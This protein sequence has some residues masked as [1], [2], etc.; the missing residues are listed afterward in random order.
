MR[1]CRTASVWVSSLSTGFLQVNKK[2]AE[3]FHLSV[4]A[5]KVCHAT[6][7]VKTSRAACDGCIAIAWHMV[8]RRS[9]CQLGLSGVQQLAT[10]ECT[11]DPD[12]QLVRLT[13]TNFATNAEAATT[14]HRL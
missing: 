7:Q 8:D 2:Q 6:H 9:R 4:L 12:W 10:R 3:A 1:H 5:L 11:G 13:L 14:P